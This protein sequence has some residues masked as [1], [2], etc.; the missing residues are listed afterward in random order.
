MGFGFNRSRARIFSSR[1]QTCDEYMAIEYVDT[2]KEF[3]LTGI[4]VAIAIPAYRG[5]I[6]VDTMLGLYDSAMQL[7]K[8][9]IRNAFLIEREN[10]FIENARNKLVEAFLNKTNCQ[11]LMFIDDDI[12]FKYSDLERML[13][14]S[15]LYPVVCATYPCRGF[16]PI[17]YVNY[18]RKNPEFNEHG[19]LKIRGCGAGF[20]I[21]DR[22]M[23][24]KMRGQEYKV[25]GEMVHDYFFIDI[26]NR[27]F[28]GEDMKFL[29][30]WT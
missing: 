15:T 29:E 21:L 16:P 6:P 11:K 2:R 4:S 17:F 27:H 23:F 3:D 9:G 14:W 20:L 24:E 7:T 1:I 26:R 12:A 22:S 13:C 18:D 19:L 30:K 28:H 8:K 10:A 25:Q 5:Y